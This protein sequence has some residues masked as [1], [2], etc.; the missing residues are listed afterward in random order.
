[1][2]REGR[3]INFGVHG[4]WFFG[5]GNGAKRFMRPET[6]T[7]K[8]GKHNGRVSAASN[9]FPK[10]A[11]FGITGV[12]KKMGMVCAIEAR[13]PKAEDI[14]VLG[15][16]PFNLSFVQVTHQRDVIVLR[17]MNELKFLTVPV[18]PLGRG[19]K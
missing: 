6:S 19:P 11:K 9:T 2:M 17:E 13:G 15:F 4:K 7:T 16:E 14:G 8:N 12:I 10:A 3:Q 5:Q 1:M 18:Q